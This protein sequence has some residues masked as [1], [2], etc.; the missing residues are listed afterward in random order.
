L[1][2]VAGKDGLEPKDCL[3]KVHRPDA[4]DPQFRSGR[5]QNGPAHA[6]MKILDVQVEADPIQLHS[7]PS[8]RCIAQQT[9]DEW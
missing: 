4:L 7:A 3:G 2:L 1:L 5:Q 9:V 6:L 8:F